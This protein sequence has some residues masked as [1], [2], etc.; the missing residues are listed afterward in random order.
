MDTTAWGYG[1][2]T[3]TADGH[4]LDTWFPAPAL[5]SPARDAKP[6]RDLSALAGTHGTAAARR[7]HTE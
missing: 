7:V 6:D 1:L 2:A 3:V 4:T 5:G